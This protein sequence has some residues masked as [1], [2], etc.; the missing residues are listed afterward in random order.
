MVVERSG[1]WL[2]ARVGA[3]MLMMSASRSRYIGLNEVGVRIWEL[4]ERPL[5]VDRLCERLVQEFD[6]TPEACRA[7]VEAFLQ[8][9]ARSGAAAL[10]D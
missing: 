8:E 9:L 6:V 2:A 10:N 5:S 4:I 3:E 1:D 7:D